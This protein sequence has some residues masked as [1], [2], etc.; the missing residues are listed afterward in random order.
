[1]SQMYAAYTNWDLYRAYDEL[2]YDRFE[3]LYNKSLKNKSKLSS[4]RNIYYEYHTGPIMYKRSNP[5][6]VS[7]YDQAWMPS[8]R[9]LLVS[10][11][12]F[13]QNHFASLLRTWWTSDTLHYHWSRITSTSLY[14]IAKSPQCLTCSCNHIN[15]WNC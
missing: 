15:K 2:E 14:S 1:M 11:K 6:M 10:R 5:S 8:F 7:L 12:N 3:S 4:N 13:I 9:V